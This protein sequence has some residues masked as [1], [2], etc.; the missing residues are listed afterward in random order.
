MDDLSPR[1]VLVA[2]AGKPAP[3]G[4]LAPKK[5]MSPWSRAV[6]PS[7]PVGVV[8]YTKLARYMAKTRRI[9]L[10]GGRLPL[11]TMAGKGVFTPRT[12]KT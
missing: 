1:L 4:T 6:L 8:R 11:R 7:N 12:K 3:W 9:H 10:V 5:P 2:V